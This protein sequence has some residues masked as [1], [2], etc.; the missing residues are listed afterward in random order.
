[1]ASRRKR[2]TMLITV[3]VP[4]DMSAA[5]ARLEVR[6]LINEQANYFANE[7]DVK[8]AAIKPAAKAAKEA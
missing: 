5:Q 3:T 1:M 6:T 7:G 4:A 8:A 2:V